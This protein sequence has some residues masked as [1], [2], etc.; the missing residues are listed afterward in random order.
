MALAFSV[1]DG[2]GGSVAGNFAITILATPTLGITRPV[3]N[4]TV[5]SAPASAT[6]TASNVTGVRCYALLRYATGG[7]SRGYWD[8]NS[9]TTPVFTATNSN[10]ANLP[11]ATTGNSFA[12]WSV[13][14]PALRP[15]QYRLYMRG[16]N[17][18]GTRANKSV[19]LS[20]NDASPTVV[21]TDPLSDSTVSQGTLA[22]ATGTAN[23]ADG[24]DSVLVRLYRKP[25][26]GN[27]AGYWN[28]RSYDVSYNP[29]THE[30][31]ATV[32]GT[33]N[34]DRHDQH[35]QHDLEPE[36]VGHRGGDFHISGYG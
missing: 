36:R 13:A 29:T 1:S 28:G 12:N 6:G 20:I 19:L 30:R 27:T 8:G 26:N 33:T 22:A 16:T 7:N 25:V 3:N 9:L 11:N 23:D 15:G 14:L 10:S 4:S 24:I 32:T 35:D 31:A 5:T 34:T 2:N 17:A 18:V 21:I